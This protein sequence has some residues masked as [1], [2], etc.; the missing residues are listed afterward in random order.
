MDSEPCLEGTGVTH[1]DVSL[2]FVA[3]SGARLF[4]G[5]KH[6]VAAVSALRVSFVLCL[7]PSVEASLPSPSLCAAQRVVL[8]DDPHP[9]FDALPSLEHATRLVAEALGKGS[10]VLVHCFGGQNR[11]ATVVA[12]FL[13][14]NE[15]F[16]H[17]TADATV[18][19][20]KKCRPLV[21]I[22]AFYLAQLKKW[23]WGEN[24]D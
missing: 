20:L 19:H 7:C 1:D 6:S 4:L 24:C 5:N 14:R 23:E 2:V 12:A 17:S 21:S 8:V 15:N 9:S 13:M 11:S 3:S 16:A 10:S 18:A 22:N